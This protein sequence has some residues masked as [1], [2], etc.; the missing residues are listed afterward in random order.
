LQKGDNFHDP[1]RPTSRLR[2]VNEFLKARAVKNG[3]KPQ[4]HFIQEAVN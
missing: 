4:V 2:Y 3:G 1:D